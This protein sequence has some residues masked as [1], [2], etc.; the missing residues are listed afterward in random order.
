LLLYTNKDLWLRCGLAS[1]RLTGA[2]SLRLSG[3]MA[4]P[5]PSVCG[6]EKQ[7]SLIPGNG[8]RLVKIINQII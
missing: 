5:G 4:R 3:A 8:K 7:M 2:K 1:R 6:K